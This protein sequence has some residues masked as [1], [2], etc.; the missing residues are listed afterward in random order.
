MRTSTPVETSHRS[1]VEWLVI[2]IELFV[3]V[4]AMIC[5]PLLILTDG[6]GM[7]RS[8][9]DA[10]P[11]A[12]FVIPGVVLALVGIALVIAG[13]ALLRRSSRSIVA[14]LV[15]GCLLLGWIVIETYWIDAG[16]GLQ[17]AIAAAALSIVTG[18]LSLHR[19][20]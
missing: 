11:F 7:N 3:G 17:L 5:G 13:F 6:L 2:S 15:A 10:T 9:L 16:R 18:S 19:R 8:E 4:M 14:S 1:F 20:Q 12:S